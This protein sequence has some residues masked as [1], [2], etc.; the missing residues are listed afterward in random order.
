MSKN[1]QHRYKDVHAD[2][3]TV[4]VYALP[5]NR[6][7]LVKMLDFYIARLPSNPKAFYL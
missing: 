6:K 7:C 4:R 3:K 1:N 2:N 5:E